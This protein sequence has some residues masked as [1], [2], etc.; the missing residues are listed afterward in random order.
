[1]LCFRSVVQQPDALCA[2]VIT[3]TSCTAV[4]LNCFYSA[5][6]MLLLLHCC[7]RLVCCSTA[8]QSGVGL[9]AEHGFFIRPPWRR[10]WHSRF[11]LADHSWQAMVLPILKQVRCCGYSRVLLCCAI[12]CMLHSMMSLGLRC[13]VGDVVHCLSG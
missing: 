2:L 12:A 5:P 11:P 3:L 10:R 4:S 8:L 13:A 7:H 6:N 1:M 9:A